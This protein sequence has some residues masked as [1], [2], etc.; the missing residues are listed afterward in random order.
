MIETI[1]ES[2]VSRPTL[3]N[4]GKVRDIHDLDD[5]R[6]I[7]TTGCSSA[8]DRVLPDPIPGKGPVLTGMPEHWFQSTSHIVPNH[9]IAT[10]WDREP[11]IPS[12]PAE[13]IERTVARYRE[14]QALLAR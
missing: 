12:L 2:T 10:G 4:R 5:R 6:L 9:L 8:F 14:A 7:V 1:T 13:I 3:F 11:P